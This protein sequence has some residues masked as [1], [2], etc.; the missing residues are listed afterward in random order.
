MTPLIF[1]GTIKLEELGIP[2]C[3]FLGDSEIKII[4]DRWPQLKALDI[5]GWKDSTV[6]D[7][8]LRYVAGENRFLPL[9]TW[10][11]VDFF[12]ANCSCSLA[13]TNLESLSLEGNS[14]L[15]DATVDHI[16]NSLLKLK[17]LNL[18]K[19][20]SLTGTSRSPNNRVDSSL[21]SMGKRRL[22]LQKVLLDMCS[23]ITDEGNDLL[24]VKWSRLES[25][26]SGMP[27]CGGN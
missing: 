24:M 9:L 14:K 5:G 4:V 15:S 11:F 19:C 10:K 25:I 8:G 2:R 1:L 23:K 7:D 21:Q 3:P 13:L 18:I 16:A 27:E 20:S 6:T 22:P 26:V 17:D 12:P